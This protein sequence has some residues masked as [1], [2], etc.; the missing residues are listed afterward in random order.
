[1][2]KRVIGGVGVFTEI[3]NAGQL[4][5]GRVGLLI[6]EGQL[7]ITK[8]HTPQLPTLPQKSN[9]FS[10]KKLFSVRVRTYMS[11]IEAISSGLSTACSFLPSTLSKLK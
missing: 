7:V 4:N 9:I 10:T 5:L 8:Y 6:Y 11:T 3:A 1:M 2:K